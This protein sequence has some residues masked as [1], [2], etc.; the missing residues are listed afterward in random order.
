MAIDNRQRTAPPELEELENDDTP[1]DEGDNPQRNYSAEDDKL[2]EQETPDPLEDHA[3]EAEDLDE[4]ALDEAEKEEETPPPAEEKKAP[5]YEERYKES[6][7]EAQLLHER[8][9]QLTDA[10]QKI[11]EIKEPTEEELQAAARRDG[12]YWE[13]LTNTEK[14]LIKKDY[15]NTRKLEAVQGVVKDVRNIDEWAEKVDSFIDTNDTKQT[16]KA[17]IGHEAEFRAFALKPSHR[18]LPVEM[19]VSHFL[20]TAEPTAHKKGS[21]F[22]TNTGGEKEKPKKSGIDDAERAAQLRMTD[23]KKY[24]EL[25]R[26]GK[27]NIEI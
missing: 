2:N 18:G 26:S 24:R 9:K 6:T 23:P 27:I 20:M 8:N 3:D 15:I 7:K 4:K 16:H 1:I 11:D 21:L 5:D 17:L 12:L 19:L 10:F 25:L 14:L 13:E 22:L